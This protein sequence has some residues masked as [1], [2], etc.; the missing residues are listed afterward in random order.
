MSE[1]MNTQTLP[2]N[3]RYPDIKT[4]Y[5]AV[6]LSVL[7]DK[8]ILLDYWTNSIDKTV[9][10]GIKTSDNGKILVKSKEEYTST[11]SNLYKSG[12]DLIVVTENSIYIVD[13]L[14]PRKQL[15]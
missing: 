9:A 7:D 4:F 8:P 13:A 11:I 5:N 6:K 10:L 1:I 2:S 12:N 14:I 15:N 3:H